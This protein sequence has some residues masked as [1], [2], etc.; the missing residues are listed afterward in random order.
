MVYKTVGL[1]T[2]I[3]SKE[4]THEVFNEKVVC[5]VLTIINRIFRWYALY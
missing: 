4:D 5:I 1:L 2:N 3:T